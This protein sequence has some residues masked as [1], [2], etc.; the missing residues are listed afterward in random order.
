[1]ALEGG[2]SPGSNIEKHSASSDDMLETPHGENSLD[3]GGDGDLFGD[4]G[5]EQ[6]D[7]KP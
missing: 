2:G 1:M 4:E 3:T 5:D 7:I 6:P